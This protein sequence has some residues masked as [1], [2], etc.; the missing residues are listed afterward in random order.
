MSISEFLLCPTARPGVSGLRGEFH[1]VI[2]LNSF[3]ASGSWEWRLC[4]EQDVSRGALETA[5]G[6]NSWGP[7]HFPLTE[8]RQPVSVN[9]NLSEPIS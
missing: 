9:Q 7:G 4:S 6:N 3:L 5:H 1:P 8:S 2:S